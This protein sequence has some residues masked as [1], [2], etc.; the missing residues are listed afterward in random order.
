MTIKS[1]LSA[2]LKVKY[3]RMPWMFEQRPFDGPTQLENLLKKDEILKVPGAHTAIAGLMA[4]KTG[5]DAVYVSGAA[6]SASRALPDLG[7][8]TVDELAQYIHNL[9]R[10]T[11][12]PIIVDVDT[13]F[14]EVLFLGRTVTEME[15]AGAACIQ[16][17]DQ[18]LPKKCGHVGGK[19]LVEP[20][21]FCRKIE[22]AVKTRR[23]LKILART[24]A[25]AL[26]GIDE[27]IRRAKM[28]VDAGADY[29]FPEALHTEEEFRHF[30]NEV[31]VPLL[32]NMTE[33]GKTPYYSAAQ[34]QDMGYKIVI[35]PVTSLRVAM[36][37]IEKV[38]KEIAETGSQQSLLD[39]MQ[40][41]GE[42]YELIDYYGYEEVDNNIAANEY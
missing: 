6:F 24:D 13:G 4:K 15:D 18:L 10:S 34:F 16:M 32:A 22:A 38:Y 9:Y 19:R 26:H 7:Y 23:T 29:I 36:K 30:A 33:F 3:W 14:G 5:F 40:T 17:E 20:E 28:Y 35:Y 1:A 42:L 37:A 41:R 8:Y 27:A 25:H 2:R 12:L 39:E 11:G 21:D 31:K